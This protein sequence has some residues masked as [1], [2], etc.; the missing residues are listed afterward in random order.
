MEKDGVGATKL[1]WAETEIR[2]VAPRYLRGFVWTGE[3][4]SHNPSVEYSLYAE[5]LPRPPATAL[6]NLD[7]SNLVTSHPHLFPIVTPINVDLFEKYLEPHPNRAF[8][9]SVV[10]GLREGFWPFAKEV[11]GLEGVTLPNHPSV[12]RDANVLREA[13]DHELEMGRFSDPFGNLLP[14]MKTSPLGLV[15]K[16]HSDKFRLITDHSAGTDALNSFINRED[17]SVRYDNLRDLSNSLLAYRA[18][19]GDEVL[20]L[21]KSDIAEAFRLLPVHPFWQAKQV[22]E[23]D[24]EHYVDHNLVFGSRA[25]PKIWCAFAS[26]VGWIA[27]H[28][29]GINPMQHYMDDFWSFWKSPR[30]T[31]YHG[32]LLPESQVRFLQ[33]LDELGIPHKPEKQLYGHK[34]TI[35]GFEVDANAMTITLASDKKKELVER[36]RK[37]AAKVEDSVSGRMVDQR[38]TLR[39]WQQM[40]GELNWA[41]NILPLARAGLNSSYQRIRTPPKRQ[42]SHSK[43]PKPRGPHTRIYHNHSTVHDLLWFASRLESCSGVHIIRSQLWPPQSAQRTA[44]V[45]ACLDGLGIFLPPR[46]SW[47]QPIALFCR[48]EGDPIY[49]DILHN[50]M[51]AILCALLYF[52]N[53]LEQDLSRILIHSDSLDSVNIFHSFSTSSSLVA[54]VLMASADVIM[55]SGFSPRVIH[56]PGKDNVEADCISR[57]MFIQVY[58]KWPTLRLISIQ[59]P[60]DTLGARRL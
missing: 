52:A 14:G 59:P 31:L 39:E 8:V 43:A 20:M 10:Q 49:S 29:L 16:P 2:G 22:V 58:E 50:E 54:P 23:I 40:L 47:E 28:R 21:W 34:L 38:P 12:V 27:L 18:V 55:D 36:I 25:S 56:I 30:R 35:I 15:P 19:H 33:L 9:D 13:R 53:H 5:P 57:A 60:R 42:E 44:F 41:L 45:D 24:G 7:V 1:S 51:L 37:F 3:E 11:T 6:A 48:L 46:G 32:R 26:L 17:V 4:S